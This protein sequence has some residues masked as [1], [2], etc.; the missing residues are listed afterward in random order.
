MFRSNARRERRSNGRHK[1]CRV[2][3]DDMRKHQNPA[4]K[5]FPLGLVAVVA[6]VLLIPH[7]AGPEQ[8]TPHPSSSSLTSPSLVSAGHGQV[9]RSHQYVRHTPAIL[10]ALTIYMEARGESFQ[11]KLA[12]AAVIRNRMQAKYHSDGTVAGTVLKPW[13]FQP[14]NYLDPN[15]MRFDA[16]DPRMRDSLRAW[17]LVQDGRRVV[18]GALLFYNP[19]LVKTPLWALVSQKV[20][21]VGRH[22]FFV[23]PR[24]RV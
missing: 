24:A 19:R 12:V 15:R 20:S 2:K 6:C 3:L 18:D 7:R 11:S 8:G 4:R 17:I 10:A 5:I 13:Q 14:W 1:I 9:W 23:P 22:L 21:Q 16:S